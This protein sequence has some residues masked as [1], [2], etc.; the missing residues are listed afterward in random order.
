MNYITKQSLTKNK[1]AVEID[2]FIRVPKSLLRNQKYRKLTPAAKL[3]YMELLDRVGISIM[4]DWTDEEGRYYVKFSKE[5]MPEALGMAPKTFDR[6]K[7]PLEESGLIEIHEVN[8]RVH[9]I[10]V[11]LPEEITN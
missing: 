11:S 5:S 2:S 7:K 1:K 8:S 10:Y 4:N 3:I 6:N 9:H